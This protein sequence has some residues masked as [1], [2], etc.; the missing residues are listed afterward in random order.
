MQTTKWKIEATDHTE[1]TLTCEDGIIVLEDRDGYII[2]EFD[3]ADLINQLWNKADGNP[4][5]DDETVLVFG[6]KGIYT[7]KHNPK[8][9]AG[10]GWWKLNSKSHYCNPTHWMYL[11]AKPEVK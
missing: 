1:Y 5:A 8:N 3:E 2:C 7:A 4:P 6:G 11:P 9:V 10:R